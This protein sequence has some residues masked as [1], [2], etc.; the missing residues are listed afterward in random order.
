MTWTRRRIGL[1]QDPLVNGYSAPE[2]YLPSPRVAILLVVP[3]AEDPFNK[4]TGS[5]PNE[6]VPIFGQSGRKLAPVTLAAK[7]VAIL[8]FDTD[9]QDS[10]KGFPRWMQRESC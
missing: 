2:A 8:E 5:Y 1:L 10:R 3:F 6:A 7:T 9:K 4:T